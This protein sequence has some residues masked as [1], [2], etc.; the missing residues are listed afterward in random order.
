MEFF[1][2]LER[3]SLDIEAIKKLLSISALPTH[4]RSIDSVISENI[5]VGEIYC[6][7]GQFTISR[8]VIRNGVRFALL[9]CPHALAWTITYRED[10]N[11]LVIHCTIDD[12]EEGQEFI[13]SIQEF[14][15]DWDI[16]LGNAI[17]K[18]T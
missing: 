15:S 12:R 1:K 17:P 18:S 7:W 8:Q 14:I 3:Q 16:G 11:M 13:E 2:E 6:V 4:C 10:Q 9:D 5:N